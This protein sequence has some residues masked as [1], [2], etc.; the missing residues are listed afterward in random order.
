MVYSFCNILDIGP[1]GWMRVTPPTQTHH[2][3][4]PSITARGGFS[5]H[6]VYR[7]TP[8]RQYMVVLLLGDS[9]RF[10]PLSSR[11]TVVKRRNN[12]HCK[13]LLLGPRPTGSGLRIVGR[14]SLNRNS[15]CVAPG[16]VLGW[17]V[18]W[19]VASPSS[20]WLKPWRRVLVGDTSWPVGRARWCR[21]DGTIMRRQA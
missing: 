19:L 13:A 7:N 11:F 21:E 16:T 15:H 18:V 10:E 1:L 4:H 9:L 5:H 2:Q 14:T 12:Q 20:V 8:W 3:P 6:T 17:G